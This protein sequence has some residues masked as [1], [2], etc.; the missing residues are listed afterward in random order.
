M[1]RVTVAL[2]IQP[3]MMFSGGLPRSVAHFVADV[4]MFMSAG[5]E[6]AKAGGK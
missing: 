3:K 2:V 4:G 6:A 5:T 1:S